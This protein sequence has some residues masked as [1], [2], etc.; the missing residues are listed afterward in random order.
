MGG[1]DKGDSFEMLALAFRTRVCAVACI[2][3]TKQ[4]FVRL[5]SSESIPYIETDNIY[6]AVRW[7]MMEANPG[8]VLL[9]S[10]GCASFGL[11]RDY[12]DRAEKFREALERYASISCY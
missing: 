3:E 4:H 11:F 2:G 7:L 5:A 6:E 12:L 8:D 1:S 9:L 10:P